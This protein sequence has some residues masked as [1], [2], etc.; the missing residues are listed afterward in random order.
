MASV[1]RERLDYKLAFY[2]NLLSYCQD[3]RAEGKE[4][5]LGGD[6]KH[7]PYADRPGPAH[8]E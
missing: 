3:L 8:T 2:E 5:I 6:F 1:T 4:I 7:L